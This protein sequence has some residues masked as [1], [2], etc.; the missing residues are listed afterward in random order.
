MY[1]YPH[2][3]TFAVG[4]PTC[5]LLSIIP[6]PHSSCSQHVALKQGY[7]LLPAAEVL[8]QLHP[9]HT[10]KQSRAIVSDV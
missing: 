8:I 3:T 6:R 9:C 7:M 5:M 10:H 2:H 4:I 1:E